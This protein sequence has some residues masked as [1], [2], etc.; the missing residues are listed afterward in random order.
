MSDQPWCDKV[1][2]VTG[3][4]AG[5]GLAIARSALMQGASVAICGRRRERLDDAA[6]RLRDLGPGR[7]L[8][9]G[10][11]L[12]CDQDAEYVASTTL[13]ELGG[14]DMLCNCVGISHRAEILATTPAD[15]QRLLEMNLFAAVRMS[16]ALAEPLIEK[17]GHLVNIGS[18]A[19]KAAP[20]YLGAYPVSKFALAAY[21]QQLRLELGPRGLHVL[22]VCPGPIARDDAGARY[23]ES[24]P[25]LPA[26]AHRAGGGA[27]VRSIEP[28]WLADKILRACQRR[29]TE[30]V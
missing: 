6:L 2:S 15:I 18:L 30:L 5:L 28:D 16:R 9:I 4:S 27:K 8:P 20:R 7:V 13:E 26:A 24:A 21:T 10:G 22:H 14:L 19:S 12:T 3:G 1:V 29:K 23:A 11:D 17:K 25:S